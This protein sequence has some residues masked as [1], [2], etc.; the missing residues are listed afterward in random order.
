L[1]SA[2]REREATRRKAIRSLVEA[3]A[4]QLSLFDQRDL[5][6]IAVPESWAGLG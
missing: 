2:Q 5:A 1:I 6:E 3:G 4:I